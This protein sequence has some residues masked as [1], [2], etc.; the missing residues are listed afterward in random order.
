M[1]K[2]KVTFSGLNKI[3]KLTKRIFDKDIFTNRLVKEVGLFSQERVKAV[4]R[5]GYGV[6]NSK[7]KKLKRLSNSYKDMRRG[8]VK[9]RTVNGAVIPFQE[10]DER[11]QEVDKKFFEPDFSNLTFSG[12][13]LESIKYTYNRAKHIFTIQPTGK[14]KKL[15]GESKTLTNKKVA[16]YVAKGG[17]PF[18][19]IDKKGDKTIANM[20]KREI[21]AQLRKNNLKK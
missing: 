12:Q 2:T 14:R 5:T 20:I 11:I 10:P 16:E 9:F 6:T 21:R 19:G 4:T 15:P 8:A 3:R 13:L 7:K 17:R 18:L 1:G